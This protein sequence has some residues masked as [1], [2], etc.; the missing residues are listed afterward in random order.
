ME[1]EDGNWIGREGEE[2]NREARKKIA[3]LYSEFREEKKLAAT[4]NWFGLESNV[5]VVVV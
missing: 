3:V 5:L 2:G 4:R 1:E